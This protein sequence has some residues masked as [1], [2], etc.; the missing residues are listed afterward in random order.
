MQDTCLLG[1][2]FGGGRGGATR[3]GEGGLPFY[4]LLKSR[5][6]VGAD[7]VVREIDATS[8]C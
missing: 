3:G 4:L 6:W 5:L 8:M 1:Y 2:F 7:E